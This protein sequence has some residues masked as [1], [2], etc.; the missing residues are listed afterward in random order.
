MKRAG[1]LL[2]KQLSNDVL[3]FQEDDESPSLI[4]LLGKGNNTGDALYAAASFSENFPDATVHLFCCWN[5]NTWSDPVF[6]AFEALQDCA[7]IASII[8]LQSEA[9]F[10]DPLEVITSQAECC[11]AIDG[12]F[13]MNFK[14]PLQGHPAD[15]IQAV[16]QSANIRLRVAVDIP[17]GLSENAQITGQCFHSDIT[18]A[19]GILKTPSAFGSLSV[20]GRLK[21]I[22]LNFFDE[23]SYEE[24]GTVFSPKALKIRPR[25]PNTDKRSY[26]HL[27]IIAGSRQM[28]GA[29]MMA[30]QAAIRSGVGLVTVCAPES[31]CIQAA[32]HFPEA[33]WIPAPESESGE[34]SLE[35]A[36][37]FAQ[38]AS[39]ATALLI[40]PGMG[41]G[42]ETQDLI[43]C[44]IENSEDIPLILDADA[45]QPRQIEAV[46]STKSLRPGTIITP[47]PGEL[48]RIMPSNT[49]SSLAEHL[50]GIVVEKG[51]RTWVH[52]PERSTL[53][54][55]G[56]PV[57][58]RGGSGDILAG[59]IAGNTASQ[60]NDLEASACYATALHARAAD[61]LACAKGERHIATTDLFAYL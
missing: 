47:H 44:V 39:R 8:N 1:T 54:P 7:E 59:L 4:L 13:G 25:K 30:T 31:L 36:G 20:V 50:D 60:P 41:R 9:S 43:Q 61:R 56:N 11:I 40:G 53:I 35:A 58:A 14:T 2:G 15:L 34:L 5:P 24:T 16:N 38:H 55:F 17:S 33:M 6:R 28:P 19:T 21:M 49:A 37:L 3:A 26:G 10:A 12:I 52:S 22:D 51:P 32:V 27:F 46:Q 48:R 57:L 23:H 29:L 18:Y 45:L 42:A